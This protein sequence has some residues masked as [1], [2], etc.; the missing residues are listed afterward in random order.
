[1]S[2]QVK[3]VVVDTN[4]PGRLA[5]RSVPL[6]A[7]EKDEAIVRVTAIS[8]NR[9][10]VKRALTQS[11]TGA[12]PGWDFA[13]VVETAASA[14]GPPGGARV[15]GLLPTGGWAERVCVPAQNLAL[16]PDDVSDAQAATLPVAGWRSCSLALIW[17]G[18]AQAHTSTNPHI[19]IRA[20]PPA[21]W[22][23]RVS[24]APSPMA[25]NDTPHSWRKVRDVRMIVSPLVV[26]MVMVLVLVLG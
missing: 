17:R 16:L 6:A 20:V 26:V 15:V 25:S 24:T 19:A 23:W 14:G 4:A 10:E 18:L 8:L 11:E 2:E 5:I 22:R 21:S 9:G 12:R 7:P 1:M 13:G 3:A